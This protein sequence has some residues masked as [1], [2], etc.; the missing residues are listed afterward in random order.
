MKMFIWN[1]PY[2]VN[3]GTSELVVVAEDLPA[4]IELAKKSIDGHWNHHAASDLSKESASRPPD[5]TIELPCA[6]NFEWSE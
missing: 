4:A 3:Y 2:Q 5:K 1:D 6:V